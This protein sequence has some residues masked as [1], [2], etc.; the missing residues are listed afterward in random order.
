MGVSLTFAAL[1]ID[2]CMYVSLLGRGLHT[3][4]LEVVITNNNLQESDAQDQRR[5]LYTRRS[6]E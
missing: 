3:L 6:R 4:L 2:V 1:I 5:R